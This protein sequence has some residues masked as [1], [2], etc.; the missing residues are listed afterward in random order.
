MARSHR[1]GQS[2]KVKVFRLVTRNT[3]ESEMVE[4]ANKKLGLERAMNADRANDGLKDSKDSKHGPPQDRGEIDAM[5]KRGAHDIFINEDD[6]TAFQKFNESDIDEILSKSSTR[7]S[8]DQAIRRQPDSSHHTP[9]THPSGTS[10]VPTRSVYH[11]PIR[12]Q[13]HTPISH[14]S[15]THQIPIR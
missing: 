1:I 6:D 10:Q 14:P 11:A 8:Y 15:V 7:V 12:Y 3:Y 13:S 4:R 5:L 9:I 2:R